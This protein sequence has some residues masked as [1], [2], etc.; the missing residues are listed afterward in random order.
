MP[1]RR[2]KFMSDWAEF[3]QLKDRIK[4]A[5]EQ[6]QPGLGAK[7]DQIPMAQARAW[8][9]TQLG[10]SIPNGDVLPMMRR[11]AVAAERIAQRNIRA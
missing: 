5:L 4:T 8:L 6:I 11:F 7:F 3:H 2:V 10:T 9:N 1:R